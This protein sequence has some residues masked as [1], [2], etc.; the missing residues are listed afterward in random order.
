MQVAKVV[1]YEKLKEIQAHDD[2]RHGGQEASSGF[3]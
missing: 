1:V 2:Q 3:N